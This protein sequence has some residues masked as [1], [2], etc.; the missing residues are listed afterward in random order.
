MLRQSRSSFSKSVIQCFCPYEILCVIC[1]QS[2]TWYSY[3]DQCLWPTLLKNNAE[4]SLR[5]NNCSQ[6]RSEIIRNFFFLFIDT[7]ITKTEK[8]GQV[9]ELITC[10]F[11]KQRKLKTIQRF[12]TISYLA[13]AME[14]NQTTPSQALLLLLP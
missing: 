14:Y 3:T 2:S 10:T 13:N 4:H 9:E 6:R 1:T 11:Q 12:E 7:V 8:M 5:K